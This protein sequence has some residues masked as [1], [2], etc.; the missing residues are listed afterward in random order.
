MY[1]LDTAQMYL[2]QEVAVVNQAV[3][4]CVCVCDR[5]GVLN[6]LATN[7]QHPLLEEHPFQSSFQVLFPR[8]LYARFL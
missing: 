4:V 1:F 7:L 6:H 2:Q 3:H 5:K 8:T